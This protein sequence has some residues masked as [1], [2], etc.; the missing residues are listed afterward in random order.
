MMSKMNIFKGFEKKIQIIFLR[1][2]RLKFFC[3]CLI[4]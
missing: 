4:L 1:L 3:L 2:M